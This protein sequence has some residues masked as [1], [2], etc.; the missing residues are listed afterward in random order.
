MA[1]GRAVIGSSVGGIKNLIQ[2]GRTGLLVEPADPVE[3]SAAILRLLRSA[4]ERR[5][6]GEGARAFIA[7]NF[8]QDRMADET[9]A[10]YQGLLR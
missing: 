8:S 7:E 5:R 10:V 2:D 1:A 9:E 3:L 6:L 4:G